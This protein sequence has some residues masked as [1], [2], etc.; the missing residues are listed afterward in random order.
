MSTASTTR[1]I[2]IDAPVEDVFAFVS[3]LERLMRSVPVIQRVAIGD[4][5][6]TEDGASTS[7]S[8]TTTIGIGPLRHDVHGSTTREQVVPNQHLVYRHAMGVQT[9][10]DLTLEP[11]ETGT[12]LIFTVSVTSSVPLLKLGIAAASKAGGQAQYV[13]RV[14]TKIKRELESSSAR[15]PSESIASRPSKP[16]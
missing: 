8:W 11:A 9:V 13:D 6:A 14:L 3:D 12:H 4:V 15:R 1:S 2:E 5:E 16:A 10:E 7:Y